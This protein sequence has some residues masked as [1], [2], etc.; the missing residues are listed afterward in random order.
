M[1]AA[2]YLDI[3]VAI[4]LAAAALIDHRSNRIPDAIT[5]PVI[6][7]CLAYHALTATVPLST[8]VTGAAA[9]YLVIRILHDL[10]VLI[11]GEAGIGLG[12]A[13]MLAAIGAWLGWPPLAVI[14]T[15]AALITLIA[16]R[17]RRYKPFGVGLALAA[18]IVAIIRLDL[19]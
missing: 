2:T 5:I 11:R 9:G 1:T 18:V 7:G 13:K 16:Y 3:P 8:A 12:D 4:L 14:L 15:L 17:K 6:L 10:G 19:M